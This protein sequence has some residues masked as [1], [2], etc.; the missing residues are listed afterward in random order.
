MLCFLSYF[1]SVVATRAVHCL[2]RLVSQM[3]YYAWSVRLSELTG[4]KIA[5]TGARW[6]QQP[7]AVEL[8]I[9]AVVAVTADPS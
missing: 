4:P 8:C 5:P 6:R 3:T 7:T 9:A 1:L 2:E